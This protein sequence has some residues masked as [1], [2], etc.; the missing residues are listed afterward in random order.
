MGQLPVGVLLLT[1]VPECGALDLSYLG[2]VPGARGQG[3]GRELAGKAIREAVAARAAQ[4]TLAVDARNL[5]ARQ[6]YARLG[7]EEAQAREVFL[8]FYR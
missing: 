5:P 7:F 4:L 2:V 8:A 3:F 6:L 1:A